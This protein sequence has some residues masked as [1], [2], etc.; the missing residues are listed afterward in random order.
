MRNVAKK[1]KQFGFLTL[2]IICILI[3]IMCVLDKEIP[4]CLTIIFIIALLLNGI[5][6]I[7]SIAVKYKK[8][9]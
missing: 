8:H 6:F 2:F 1:I 5:M 9:K 4:K 7:Y 3:L